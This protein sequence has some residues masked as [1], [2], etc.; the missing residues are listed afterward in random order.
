MTTTLIASAVAGGLLAAAT[1]PRA[2]Y[3][4]TLPFVTA[5]VIALAWLRE[6]RRHRAQQRQPLRAQ[7]ASTYLAILTQRALRTSSSSWVRKLAA[8]ATTAAAPAAPPTKKYSGTSLVHCGS[9]SRGIP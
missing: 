6:P 4:L 7:V 5:S 2:T 9:L 3:L 1:S 8:L